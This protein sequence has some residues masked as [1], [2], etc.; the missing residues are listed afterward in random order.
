MYRLL[1]IFF[2]A[3]HSSVIL[4]VLFGWIWRKTRP[5]HLGLVIL[6]A[7]SWFGLGLWFGIGYCP[8]TD[9]HWRVRYAMGDYDLPNSYV[10]F[11]LD[12]LTGL[13]FNAGIVDAA[14]VTG[15]VMACV[16]SVCLNLRDRHRRKN[17]MPK[18]E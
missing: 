16:L 7:L 3:F 10:K 5:A 9:W 14:T 1:D 6:T 11:L 15:F 12:K 13:D 4:F 17:A 8:F 2:F 18:N